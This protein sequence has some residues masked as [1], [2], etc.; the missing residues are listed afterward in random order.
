MFVRV[1]WRG[2]VVLPVNSLI[3]FFALGPETL[4]IATP[5]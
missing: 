5:E 1:A 4:M 3:V 2:F